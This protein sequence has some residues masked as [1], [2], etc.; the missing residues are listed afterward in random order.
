MSTL[1]RSRYRMALSLQG[2][3][4]LPFVA[5]PT[6]SHEPGPWQVLICSHFYDFVISGIVYK[7]NHTACSHLSQLFPLG[8]ILL[9]LCIHGVLVL[10]AKWPCLVGVHH[11]VFIL[12]LPQ[13]MARWFPFGALVN[14]HEQ[15]CVWAGVFL[16]LGLGVRGQEG[17]S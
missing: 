13:R 5:R 14:T 1:L 4:L 3:L 16:A 12:S 6:S 2:S 7:W 15:L 10:N 17:T 9:V 11:G 8:V